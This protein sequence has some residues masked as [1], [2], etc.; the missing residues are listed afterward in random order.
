MKRGI[1]LSFIFSKKR[2]GYMADYSVDIQAKL[3]GFEKLDALEK[4]IN[5]LKKKSVK[6]KLDVD[7]KKLDSLLLQLKSIKTII[8]TTVD[9]RGVDE[10][11]ERVRR[12]ANA[13]KIQLKIDT[14]Q[15][16]ADLAK[17]EAKMSQLK[18]SKYLENVNFKNAFSSLKNFQNIKLNPSNIE[19]YNKALKT[20]QNYLQAASADMGTLVLESKRLSLLDKAQKTLRENSAYTK[21]AKAQIRDY[22]AEINAL[23][24]NMS[25]LDY[26]RISDGMKAVN[27]QMQEAGKTGK[28]FTHELGR[29][30]KQIGQFAVTYGAVQRIP[31]YLKQMANSTLE[32]DT[33]MTELRKVSDES[34][35]QLNSYFEH[36]T[37]SAEKYGAKI[38][39]VINSAADWKRLGYTLEDSKKLSDITTLYQRVG[40]NMTQEKASESL[41]STLQGFKLEADEAGHIVDAFNE[42]GNN[43]AIGS[44]GI[45]EALQRSASSMMAAGNTMEQTIGLITAANEVVQDP[46][47][48]GNAFK[49]ISMRIRGAETEMEELGLDTDGMAESTAKLQQEMLALSGIDIMKDKDTF[50]STYDILDELSAKWQSLTD[51][52]QAS[53]TELIAGKHQGNVLSA[54]LNNFETAREATETAYNSDGSATKELNNYKKSMQ[55]SIDVFKAQFQELSSSAFSSDFLKGAVDAGTGLLN[56]LTQIVDV[57]GTIPLIL[58]AIGSIKLIKNLDHQKVLKIPIFLSWSSIDKEMIKWFKLQVYV[59]GSFKINQRGVPA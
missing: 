30:F 22:I 55:Y 43:F 34:D 42:V 38:N 50:K 12:N 52:Q 59:F 11:V 35:G 51:I 48:V 28:S 10:V 13:K 20:C 8:K 25:K 21:E 16:I 40:D 29:G 53:I 17:V 14:G 3:S 1:I 7:S 32:V 9:S 57:G 47:R 36:A 41:V 5:S 19:A 56:V 33:A 45:G 2:G 15:T 23:K 24:G 31:Y 18:G 26:N 49:T 6:I 39:E 46:D 54:L 58:G 27:M 44:D 37:E 4:Q